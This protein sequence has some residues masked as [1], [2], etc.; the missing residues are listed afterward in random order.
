MATNIA[1]MAKERRPLSFWDVAWAVVAGNILFGILSV[2]IYA[3]LMG[4]IIG[5]ITKVLGIH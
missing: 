1:P 3:I 2:V 5:G 4:S